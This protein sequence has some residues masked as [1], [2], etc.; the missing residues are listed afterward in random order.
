M[1]WS[2]N[3]SIEGCIFVLKFTVRSACGLS[4]TEPNRAKPSRPQYQQGQCSV[5]FV[6]IILSFLF[7]VNLCIVQITFGTHHMLHTIQTILVRLVT[8][9]KMRPKEYENVKWSQWRNYI[10]SISKLIRIVHRGVDCTLT[11][12]HSLP[13]SELCR[14]RWQTSSSNGKK[15]TLTNTNTHKI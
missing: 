6:L 3:E 10:F 15:R 11:T 8:A 9:H 2:G 1:L 13:A 5:L 12:R 14:K 7:I 4:W